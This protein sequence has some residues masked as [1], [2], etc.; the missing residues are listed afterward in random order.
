MSLAR[1]PY[2]PKG[3]NSSSERTTVNE[4][5]RTSDKKNRMR[6]SMNY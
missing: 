6:L 2:H 4:R 5:L 3:N 1:M